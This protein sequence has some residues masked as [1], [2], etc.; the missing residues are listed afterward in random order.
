MALFYLIMFL[1]FQK[2]C[3]NEKNLLSVKMIL[4]IDCKM[5]LLLERDESEK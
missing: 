5:A 2:K 3:M 1:F 4:C